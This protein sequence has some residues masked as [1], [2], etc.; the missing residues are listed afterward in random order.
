MCD[1][2]TIFN[3]YIDSVVQE[4]NARALGRGLE[5][6][7]ANGGRFEINRL[8]FADETALVADSEKNLCRLM[9]EFGRV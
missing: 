2:S 3:V 7:R 4:V 1:V 8:L 5:L 6:L 9:S